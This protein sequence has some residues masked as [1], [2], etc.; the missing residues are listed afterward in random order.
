AL[1]ALDSRLPLAEQVVHFSG[2]ECGGRGNR[3]IRVRKVH[4]FLIGTG[5]AGVIFIV[6]QR[7]AERIR[8]ALDARVR[9]KSFSPQL[10]QFAIRRYG[11]VFLTGSVQQIRARQTEDE[12]VREVRV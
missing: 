8:G 2:I 1:V 5:R 9:E 6:L 7:A 11:F 12:I 4:F 3:G 10:D